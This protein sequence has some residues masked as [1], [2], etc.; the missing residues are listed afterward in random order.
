VVSRLNLDRT[1]TSETIYDPNSRVERS[2]R[3]IKQNDLSQNKSTDAPAS[4]GEKLPDQGA[5]SQ[6]GKQ[7]NETNERKEEL[8]NYEVSSKTIETA[9]DGYTIE[10]LSVAVLVN[11]QRLVAAAGEGQDAVPVE[12]QLMDIEQLITSA[13]GIAKDRGDQLKVAAVA[14]VD[15]AAPADEAA[16]SGGMLDMV[17]GQVGTIINAIAIIVV[18]VLVILFGLRPAVKA[19]I[20]AGPPPAAAAAAGAPGMAALEAPV[21]LEAVAGD[22]AG[23]PMPIGAEPPVNLI[24]DVTKKMNRS[25]QKRLEQIVE[26]DEAQAAAILRQWLH[27]QGT[28]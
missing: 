14:F 5:V 16:A 23:G 11:K 26:F 27:Q 3:T 13:A 4:V 12:H 28:A 17:L 8:T 9:H 10:K 24:E 6:G 20:A 18:A 1:T 22:M 21:G 2:V 25:P 19:I 15:N 7:S